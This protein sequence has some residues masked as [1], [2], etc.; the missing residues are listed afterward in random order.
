MSLF[1]LGVKSKAE[2]V[3]VCSWSVPRCLLLAVDLDFVSDKP[4]GG[5]A[6]IEE[7]RVYRLTRSSGEPVARMR[8]ED[9]ELDL[10]VDG[11]ERATQRSG[12][13]CAVKRNESENVVVRATSCSIAGSVG[14]SV[15]GRAVALRGREE[16]EET[17]IEA[18]KP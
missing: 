1:R 12:A 14:L 15:A 18:M 9:F 11:G 3:L 6:D 17:G 5:G 13:V 2:G 8:F 4:G 16:R 10:D 7:D